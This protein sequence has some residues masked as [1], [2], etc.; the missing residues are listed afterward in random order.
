MKE[1]ECQ[2]KEIDWSID[3]ASYCLRQLKQWNILVEQGKSKEDLD[4]LI[5]SYSHLNQW[6]Y[7]FI[8]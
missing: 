4:L 1:G 7:G 5:H 3:R 2:V 8:L 6:K